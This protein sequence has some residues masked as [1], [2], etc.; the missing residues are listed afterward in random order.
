MIAE[1]SY[2]ADLIT[3]L[4]TDKSA[5][6]REG[7]ARGLGHTGGIKAVNA[8]LDA[9]QNARET[10]EVRSVAAEALGLALVNSRAKSR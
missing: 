1:E 10:S 5:T 3:I 7:A 9:A 2:I 6:A 8:L 4:T